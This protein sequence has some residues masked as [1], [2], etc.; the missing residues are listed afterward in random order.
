[1]LFAHAAAFFGISYFDQ[2]SVA[3]HA[4]LAMIV[5]AVSIRPPAGRRSR[6]PVTPSR[7]IVSQ[8]FEL[9]RS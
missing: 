8:E 3:W 4:E 9:T 5:T 6:V 7:S 2:S 1:M